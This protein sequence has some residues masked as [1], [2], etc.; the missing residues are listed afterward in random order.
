MEAS[1]TPL[2][3]ATHLLPGDLAERRDRNRAYLMRLSLRNLLL[4]YLREAGLTRVTYMPRDLHDGWDSPLSPIRGTFTGHWLSAA[5]RLR[6]ETRDGELKARADFLVSEIGRCQAENGGEWCFPIPEKYLHW[7]ERLKSVWAPQYVCHKVMAGLLDMYRYAGNEQALSVARGAARW[8]HRFAAGIDRERMSAMMSLEETGGLME[9]WADLYAVTGDPE[10]QDL[11]RRYE[12]PELFEP[13]ERGEDVLTNMH[14]NATI[15]EVQGAARAFEVTGEERYRRI[16]ESYWDLAVR[17][18]GAFAT[19][20]QTSGEVWTPPDRQAARLGDL[21]QEHC[22]VYNLMRLAEY[23]L[24]WTG[25]AEYA[26][27][28]ERNLY[29]GILAQGHWEGRRIEMRAD[30]PEPPRGLVAYYLP[31]AAGSRKGWGSETGDFW[32]CHCTLVQAHAGH[33]EGVYYRHADGLAVC[34]YLPSKVR[35]DFDGTEV[36]VTQSFDPRT[37]EI[38]RV[39]P[40][41]REVPSRPGEIRVRLVVEP[42]GEVDMALR[43]R[44]PWW[45][46]GRPRVLEGER[47]VEWREDPAGY[48]VV[49]RRWSRTELCVVLPKGL[50]TWP[51]PDRPDT[52]AFLDGPLVLAGLVGEERALVGD[53]ADPSTML[54]PDDERHWAGWQSGWHTVNQ[55]VGWR[56]K[57]LAEIGHETYTVYFPV[58]R[59]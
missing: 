58:R 37:G 4:P 54:A 49:R 53:P 46:R 3:R 2:A 50:T 9:H 15:P 30:P 27:Y 25:Q 14:A 33:R 12:R 28:W 26:D 35:F 13:L 20:G 32:C 19:G 16:V 43:F 6:D 7:L 45:L 31:L 21:T 42:A 47:D 11:V 51:L 23:L 24:R 5:A 38:L 22:T 56:F 39:Q 55:P 36:S 57:P 59:P 18:R 44:L 34:Q 40:V 17:R 48:A 8:F 10:H 41:N 29:N 52:V 1:L